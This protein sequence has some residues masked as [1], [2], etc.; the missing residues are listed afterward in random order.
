[1]WERKTFSEKVTLEMSFKEFLLFELEVER[2]N[3]MKKGVT[4]QKDHMV[5]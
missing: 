3:H 1:M 4:L 2:H 5:S